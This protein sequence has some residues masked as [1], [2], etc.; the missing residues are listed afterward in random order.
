MVFFRLYQRHRASLTFEITE[1][2]LA[3]GAPIPKYLIELVY[4]NKAIVELPDSTLQRF[5]AY[6]YKQ[7]GDD[8][9]IVNPCTLI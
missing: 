2:L 9:G 7:Y 3:L 6:G 4:G 5:L 8:L 1:S